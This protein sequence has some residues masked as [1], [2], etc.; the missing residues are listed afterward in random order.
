[1]VAGWAF[2]GFLDEVLAEVRGDPDLVYSIE[3]ALALD[4]LHLPRLDSAVVRRLAPV[5][6]RVADDVVTGARPVR[7]N[8]RVLDDDSQEQFRRAVA[9]L[10]AILPSV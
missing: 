3:K 8:G 9:E 1:V 5:L 10:R 2:R 4:G 7:A 6:S